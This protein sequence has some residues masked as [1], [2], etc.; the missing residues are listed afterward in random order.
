MESLVGK[1]TWICCEWPL[2]E[3]TAN[4]GGQFGKIKYKLP[5]CVV[6]KIKKKKIE[7][8]KK[9]IKKEI[10][11]FSICLYAQSLEFGIYTLRLQPKWCYCGRLVNY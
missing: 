8:K 1:V 2:F 11:T 7:E 3:P 4:M 10:F 5:H 6:Q 9:Q